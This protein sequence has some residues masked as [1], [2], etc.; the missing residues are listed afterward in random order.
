MNTP[1]TPRQHLCAGASVHRLLQRTHVVLSWVL[2]RLVLA[3]VG[4]VHVEVLKDET[5]LGAVKH[6]LVV[7]VER[8][9]SKVA[10]MVALVAHEGEAQR[11]GELVLGCDEA[12]VAGAL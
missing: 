10:A 2:P 8:A 1:S 6:N 7:A 4:V 9:A 11:G 3:S 12:D 5:D